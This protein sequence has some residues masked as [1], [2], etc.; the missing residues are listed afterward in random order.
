MAVVLCDKVQKSVKKC[1]HL[2]IAPP[3]TDL[4][5]AAALDFTVKIT[6]F[7]PFKPFYGRSTV[8]PLRDITGFTLYTVYDH[9]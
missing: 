3:T 6:E 8:A 5:S 7:P 4:D 2:S 1:D 9:C